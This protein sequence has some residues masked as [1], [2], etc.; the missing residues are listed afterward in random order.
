MTGI[1]GVDRDAGP[2][3]DVGFRIEEH[4]VDLAGA[5]HQQMASVDIERGPVREDLYRA[6]ARIDLERDV[7]GDDDRIAR[8]NRW[9]GIV[10][11]ADW[12]VVMAGGSRGW[13]RGGGPG[14]GGRVGGIGSG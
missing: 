8:L 10:R 14:C 12:E 2:G 11:A 9:I 13:A 4:G 6:L 7:L 3:R 1:T 5:E